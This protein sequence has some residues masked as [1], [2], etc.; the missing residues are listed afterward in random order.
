MT[1][2]PLRP[3]PLAVLLVTVCLL[4]PV[5][6][7]Y[8]HTTPVI[9]FALGLVH[10]LVLGGIAFGKFFKTL[11]FLSVVSV[12]LFVLNVLFPAEGVDGLHR[13]TAVFLR[14]MSL[15]S[16][17]IGC[18]FVVD[19]YDLVRSFM[20]Q[21]KLSPRIGFALFAGWNS[22]P[23]LRRDLRIIEK[24]Q[25]VRFGPRRRKLRDILRTAV[26]LLAGAVRHGERVSLSMAA[27][28]IETA[29]NRTF[30]K[31][32][33]WTGR[34]TLYCIAGALVSLTAGALVVTSGRFI[35]ELG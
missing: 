33:R 17:S 16:L 1:R 15:I 3:N 19:P 4:V 7:S 21:M 23:L 2:S 9:F 35:F 11:L 8:D 13:G 28:G 29:E 27:R 14:S 26:V 18:I 31:E 34:D 22:I 5:L 20:Q 32:S 30:I 6:L 10:L 24:A 25:A 12:G